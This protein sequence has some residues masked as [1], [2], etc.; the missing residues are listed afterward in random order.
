VPLLLRLLTWS[1]NKKVVE[2]HGVVKA[3]HIIAD[4]VDN[5]QQWN[6]LQG[7]MHA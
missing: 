5:L 7:G 3:P 2:S 4:K 1:A 6:T